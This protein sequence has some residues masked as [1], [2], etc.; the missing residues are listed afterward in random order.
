MVAFPSLS[1]LR[2]NSRHRISEAATI[3]FINSLY[4]QY[5]VLKR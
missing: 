3:L 4:L 2:I 1:T 5:L